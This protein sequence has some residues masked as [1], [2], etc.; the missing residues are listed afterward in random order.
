MLALKDIENIFK[1][2][3]YVFVKMTV[4]SSNKVSYNQQDDSWRIQKA[5]L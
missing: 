1:V 4:G 2:D 5:K 3:L